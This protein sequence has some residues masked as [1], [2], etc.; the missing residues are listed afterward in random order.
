M[1]LRTAK[2][3][4]FYWIIGDEEFGPYGPYDTKCEAEEDRIGVMRTERLMKNPNFT[5]SVDEEEIQPL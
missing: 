3:G 4:K 2:L 5:M 1:R